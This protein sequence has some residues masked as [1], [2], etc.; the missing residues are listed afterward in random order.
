MIVFCSRPPVTKNDQNTSTIQIQRGDNGGS[1]SG[2]VMIW[3]KYQVYE[4]EVDPYQDD[5]ACEIQ[6]CN[7]SRPQ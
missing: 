7:F 4:L 1:G 3:K 6:I 2:S 5:K